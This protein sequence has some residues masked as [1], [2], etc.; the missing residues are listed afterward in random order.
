[1]NG[2]QGH[3][4]TGCGL[5]IQPKNLSLGTRGTIQKVTGTHQGLAQ[6][7][8]CTRGTAAATSTKNSICLL[9]R[10][11][12][13]AILLYQGAT[14]LHISTIASHSSPRDLSLRESFHRR[15]AGG[16]MSYPSP[17]RRTHLRS[18]KQPSPNPLLGSSSTASH[19]AGPRESTLLHASRALRLGAVGAGPSRTTTMNQTTTSKNM[20]VPKFG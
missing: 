1:M 12:S 17:A 13:N 9:G 7:S 10:W 11:F 18:T 15:S 2:G 16:A 5:A 4:G 8:S 20:S 19:P 14:P 3:R 6:L